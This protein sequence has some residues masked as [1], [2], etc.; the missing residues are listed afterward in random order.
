ML[1]TS[2]FMRYVSSS[3]VDKLKSIYYSLEN[4]EFCPLDKNITVGCKLSANIVGKLLEEDRRELAGDFFHRDCIHHIHLLYY[5][6]N[7]YLDF[8]DHASF[9]HFSFV[10]Y[11]DN[12]GGTEFILGRERLFIPSERS[13]IVYFPSHLQHRAVKT[14][15]RFVAAGGFIKKVSSNNNTKDFCIN[16][17]TTS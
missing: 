9:E 1:Y 17:V 3:L 5:P 6:V 16:K 12:E 14:N 7:G 8:H 13:K 15:E 10:L 11:L 4:Y 2:P